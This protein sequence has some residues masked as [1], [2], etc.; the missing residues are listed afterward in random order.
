M[1]Q[2]FYP[3]ISS[4][5]S[6]QSLRAPQDQPV[7]RAP[8]GSNGAGNVNSNINGV[9][10]SAVLLQQHNMFLRVHIA[11][12][13]RIQPPVPV[14]LECNGA[15]RDHI[16]CS[17]DL[18]QR[19]LQEEQNTTDSNVKESARADDP[20]LHVLEKYVQMGLEKEEVAL[21]LAAYDGQTEQSQVVEFCKAYRSLVNMGFA[22]TLSA[23]ALIQHEN[24]LNAAAEAC[25]KA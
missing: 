11:S 9:V 24:D 4:G 3:V 16:Q 1:S 20:F 23:G 14:R 25:L 13:F 21:A 8:S 10:A 12:Q 17:F 5:L 22:S 2:S 19:L 7:D 15:K 18:E 6:S